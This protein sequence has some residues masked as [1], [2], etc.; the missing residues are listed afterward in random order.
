[1]VKNPPVMQETRVQFQGQEILWRRDRQLTPVFLPGEVPWTE[2]P[3]G[4]QS[5]VLHRVGYD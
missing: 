5:I 4:L 1:M 2:E 3:G